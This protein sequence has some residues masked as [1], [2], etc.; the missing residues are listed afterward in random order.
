MGMVCVLVLTRYLIKW[1]SLQI[2]G[3]WLNFLANP[4]KNAWKWKVC[5]SVIMA[6]GSL[7]KAMDLH[8]RIEPLLFPLQG[9]WCGLFCWYGIW[10]TCRPCTCRANTI[11]HNG[12][13]INP[14]NIPAHCLPSVRKKT[15]RPS[16]GNWWANFSNSFFSARFQD[17]P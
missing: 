5:T 1:R 16:I 9:D 11:F 2:I 17:W 4:Y 15:S 12:P 7:R 6:S 8:D 3:H 14:I 13:N 10:R